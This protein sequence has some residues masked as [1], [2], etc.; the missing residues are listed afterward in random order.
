MHI[1]RQ[2]FIGAI[3]LVALATPACVK[4]DP[5]VTGNRDA[6]APVA[7]AKAIVPLADPPDVDLPDCSHCSSAL[8]TNAR[9]GALCRKNS[10]RSSAIL[11]NELVGCACE[12]KCVQE[13]ANYCSGATQERACLPC[14]LS[15][16]ADLLAECSSDVPAK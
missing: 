13:C 9:R 11:L 15:G 10:V 5:I 1:D 14:I 7:A 6:A 8:D 16:C 3:A 4:D 12:D 2:L